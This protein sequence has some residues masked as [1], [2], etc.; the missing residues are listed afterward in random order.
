LVLLF[1]LGCTTDQG[2]TWTRVPSGPGTPSASQVRTTE[3]PSPGT[4]RPPPVVLPPLD[5]PKTNGGSSSAPPSPAPAPAPPTNWYGSWVPLDVWARDQQWTR[6]ERISGRSNLVCHVG[7]SNGLLALSVGNQQATFDGVNYWLGFAPVAANGR[8][9]IHGLDASKNL[10]PLGEAR[11]LPPAGHGIVVIDPGHGGDNVGT[12]SVLNRASEKEYTLD[13]A[14][15]LESLLASNGWRVVLTR[16]ND[17]DVALTNR[18]AIAERAQAD[19]FISLHFNSGAPR[20]DLAGLETFCLTPVGLPSTLTRDFEDDTARAF[21]NNAFDDQNLRLAFELH[22]ALLGVTQMPDRGIRRARFMAVL[23][24]QTRP[25]VLIE[26]GY[27]SNPKEAGLIATTGYRQK[28][29]EAVA[30]ALG[31]PDPRRSPTPSAPCEVSAAP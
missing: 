1:L 21:P 4:P 11:Q 8:M 27:L 7:T 2:T 18:V 25:A 29:A 16:T 9:F 10:R 19:L 22:R 3:S 23:R 17:V 31:T 30:A 28:L 26:A 6:P 13:W 5:R 14:L 20:Q 12:H 15:R 24:G